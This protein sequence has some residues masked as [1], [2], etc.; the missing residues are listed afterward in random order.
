MNRLYL[1]AELINIEQVVSAQQSFALLPD[2]QK[3]VVTKALFR[4]LESQAGDTQFRHA[5][6]AVF[7]SAQYTIMRQNLVSTVGD[8]GE[9]L[10]ELV[11]NSVGLE[12]DIHFA[13]QVPKTQ[14]GSGSDIDLV[15]PYVDS[16]SLRNTSAKTAV[17]I[18]FSTN[19]RARAVKSELSGDN[20][21]FIATFNGFDAAKKD[22]P[23]IG[24]AIIKDWNDGNAPVKI[25][26]SDVVIQ[27]EKERLD[28]A[29]EKEKS[30]QEG[31][32]REISAIEKS[33][34]GLVNPRTGKTW[35][36]I[37][38][39]KKRRDVTKENKVQKLKERL[40]YF[41]NNALSFEA[42]ATAMGDA[43]LHRARKP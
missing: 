28:K 8:V 42:F 23:D 9:R 27:R 37:S 25:I 5:L 32:T 33:K 34:G 4:S 20:S 13:T 29:I 43:Y 39:L 40:S 2:A 31:I 30:E 3:P 19:D 17:A 12:K 26:A 11:L 21:M 15:L 16:A 24:D 35:S 1:F 36:K 38:Q 10:L 22:M 41:Q 7:G 18:Q 14:S 6:S